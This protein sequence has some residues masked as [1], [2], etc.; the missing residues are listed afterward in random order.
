MLNGFDAKQSR[1]I[2]QTNSFLQRKGYDISKL[3]NDDYI[4]L[5][6]TNINA[7]E[8]AE[9]ELERLTP[10]LPPKILHRCMLN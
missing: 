10:T 9:E 1:S 8:D 2:M 6:A 3:T 7:P 4:C 5:Y